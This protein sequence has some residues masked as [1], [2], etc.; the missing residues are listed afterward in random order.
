MI[1]ATRTNAQLTEPS[2]VTIPSTTTPT[3]NP[4]KELDQQRIH[5]NSL[6]ALPFSS[7]QKS[8]P[9][10]AMSTSIFIIDPSSQPSPI[11]NAGPNQIVTSGS[12]ITLNGSKSKSPNGIILAYSWMQLP[13]ATG[14]GVSLGRVNT[15]EWQFV[16]PKIS[17]DTLM[18]FQL[19]VT[20][21]VGQT[22]TAFVNIL[23]KP[24][25]TFSALPQNL[26]PQTM[27]SP[28]SPA[29][30]QLIRSRDSTDN[31]SILPPLFPATIKPS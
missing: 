22:S 23:D 7:Y 20:D 1:H 8:T 11:A 27:T 16:A 2:S 28:V 15:P 14:S 17:T 3:N 21:N 26:K 12:T 18:R 6:L 30:N 9:L 13:T 24:P 29:N 4:T 5:S 25:T 31:T 19:N 10:S